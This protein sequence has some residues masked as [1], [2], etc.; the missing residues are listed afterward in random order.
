MHQCIINNLTRST[1]SGGLKPIDRVH[2]V[3]LF[4]AWYGQ[5]ACHRPCAKDAGVLFENVSRKGPQ[6]GIL[7]SSAERLTPDLAEAATLAGAGGAG[8]PWPS[9]WAGPSGTAS[10][11]CSCMPPSSPPSGGVCGLPMPPSEAGLLRQRVDIGVPGDAG[12]YCMSL[13]ESGPSS[14]PLEKHTSSERSAEDASIPT[15]TSS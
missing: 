7:L 8:A 13:S 14:G 15:S 4:L 5:V 1:S 2:A 3:L 6:L 11:A 10:S 12:E 9:A